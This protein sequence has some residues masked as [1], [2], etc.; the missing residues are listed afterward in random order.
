MATRN[1]IDEDGYPKDEEV[2]PMRVYIGPSLD[3]DLFNQPGMV[4]LAQ[5]IGSDAV[6]VRSRRSRRGRST[7]LK[8]TTA[9]R[10]SSRGDMTVAISEEADVEG[11]HRRLVGERP[12]GD[13]RLR[14]YLIC[15]RLRAGMV[16]LILHVACGSVAL[17]TAA[18]AFMTPAPRSVG[19]TISAPVVTMGFGGLVDGYWCY[20]RDLYTLEEMEQ[21]VDGH[22]LQ[23]LRGVQVC[24]RDLEP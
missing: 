1:Q 7:M 21:C 16:F 3:H 17:L 12:P 19:S 18:M 23:G 2:W 22:H 13:H 11:Y 6:G 8:R 5:W 20:H 9:R 10:S 14:G 4:G 15:G 24:D